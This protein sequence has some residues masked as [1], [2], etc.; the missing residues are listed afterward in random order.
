MHTGFGG[1]HGRPWSGNEAVTGEAERKRRGTVE[2]RQ[3]L[4]H[5][6]GTVVDQTKNRKSVDVFIFQGD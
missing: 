4:A 6:E 1:R 2:G 5:K 3:W